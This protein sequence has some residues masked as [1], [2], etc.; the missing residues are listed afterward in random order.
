MVLR[1]IPRIKQFFANFLLLDFR[2]NQDITPP[3][4]PRKIGRAYHQLLLIFGF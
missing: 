1:I 3:N 4:I 2:A